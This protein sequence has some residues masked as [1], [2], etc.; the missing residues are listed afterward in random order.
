VLGPR[1]VT[2]GREL[3]KQFEEIA[4]VAAQDFQSWLARDAN[5]LRGEFALLLHPA[6]MASEG[7]DADR[8]L[9]LLL[10]ELPLKTAVKLTAE[11]TGQPRNALYVQA[12]ALK[13]PA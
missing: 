3:T 10:A 9:G 13:N 7:G 6:P 5:R 12:L 8:I 11:I 1:L 4:T 2:V